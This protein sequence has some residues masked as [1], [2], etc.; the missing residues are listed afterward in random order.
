LPIY[1]RDKTL[2]AYTIATGVLPAFA[3]L[4]ISYSRYVMLAFP[5]LVVTADY[6][7]APRRGPA[8][9][10]LLAFLFMLQMLFLILH[11]NNNWAG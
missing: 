1:K 10:V 3:T 7:T 2:F 11:V 9:V 5:M 6:F 8:F 4:F